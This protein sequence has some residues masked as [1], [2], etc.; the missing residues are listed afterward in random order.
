MFIA[1]LY[2]IFVTVNLPYP[3]MH[4]TR[5]IKILKTFS[6]DEFKDF[7]KFVASPYFATGRDLTPLYKALKKFYPDFEGKGME[8]EKVFAKLDKGKYNDQL[9]RIM[10]SDLNKLAIEYL[11]YISVSSDTVKANSMFSYEAIKRGLFFLAEQS[12]D[13]SEKIMNASKVNNVEYFYNWHSIESQKGE[14]NFISGTQHYKTSKEEKT[15]D[16]SLFYF[17]HH[18]VHHLHNFYCLKSNANYDYSG[19]L[20]VQMLSGANLEGL[21][22]HL[23]ARKEKGKESEAVKILLYYILSFINPADE[24]YFLKLK[25]SLYKNLHHFDKEFRESMLF[26]F[27]VLCVKKI[28]EVDFDKYTLEAHECKKVMMAEGMFSRV[29]P[30]YMNPIRYHNFLAAGVAAGDHK[31]VE[32]MVK[33]HES[34]LAPEHRVIMSHYFLAE[35]CCLKNDFNGALKEISKID[36]SIFILK[37]L[38]YALQL[39]VYYELNYVD[40]ALSI[41]DTYR[42]YISNN[43]QATTIV[44]KARTDYLAIYK[45][46]L[47]YKNGKRLY[48]PEQLKLEIQQSNALHKKWMLQKATE[49]I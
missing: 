47:M 45:K 10:I 6:E 29:M 32:E 12:I 35:V 36:S 30:S 16:Y 4:E 23:S 14:Y 19:Y 18:A 5:L 26:H 9:M 43:K 39:K 42:H 21:E 28:H 13:D 1:N 33:K 27:D 11:K 22:H 41:I 8:K 38:L 37:P 3:Q 34:D 25:D 17:L 49:L 40:E 2:A 15:S 24:K 20:L 44:R 46:L 7:G 31:W 48:T